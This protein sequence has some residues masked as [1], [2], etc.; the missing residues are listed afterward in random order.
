MNETDKKLTIAIDGHSS[1]GKSTVA[2]SIA[3]LLGYTY[4][5]S[6]AMYRA[7]TLFCIKKDFI[8]EGEVD[9]PKLKE[10]LG[11]I[12]IHFTFD[13]EKQQYL[14]WLNDELVEDEIREI[15]VSDNVSTI[16]KIGAVREK[17]VLLQQEMG[18]RGGIV[19]DGR[20][21]GT[22]VFPNAD[23]K[24]FMT[25]SV[26]VRAQ[27]RFDEL[28]AKGSLVSF[29]EI[30]SNIEKRDF[31]DQNREIAPL[32]QAD[33]A[34]LIDNSFLTRKEQLN[35]IIELVNEKIK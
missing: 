17:L 6:G 23:I 26:D 34:I 18:K 33:D 2:K 3:K 35:N 21:I 16:S 13:T 25:A 31:M 10:Q 15:E 7:V 5:D 11:N 20:D 4:I 28:N 12:K 8:K 14:T 27:R 19:M 29:E 24:I 32:K 1:C 9:E 30:R 22:V